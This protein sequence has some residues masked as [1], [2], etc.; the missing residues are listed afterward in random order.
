M[1]LTSTS[2]AHT[3]DTCLTDAELNA[4]YFKGTIIRFTSNYLATKELLAGPVLDE[5]NRRFEWEINRPL[6]NL[7]TKQL[8]E[9][10]ASI[11]NTRLDN[12]MTLYELRIKERMFHCLY[13]EK[14][15]SKQLI[16]SLPRK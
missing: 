3:H 10:N 14:Y 15:S 9:D 12:Q 7:V 8:I 11:T 2:K 1:C 16:H 13:Q 5:Y 6:I 4:H